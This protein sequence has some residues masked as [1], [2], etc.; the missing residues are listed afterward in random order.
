MINEILFLILPKIA[1]LTELEIMSELLFFD[2]PLSWS[3]G[4]IEDKEG[5]RGG[6]CLS[7]QEKHYIAHVRKNA[8]GSWAEPHLLL[9]HLNGTARLA[10][11]YTTK[12]Q[13]A[14]WGKAAGLAH[15]AGKGRLV[16][17]NYLRLKSGFFD[18]EAHLEGKPGKMPHAV[19]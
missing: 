13:S 8:D 16:W 11:I 15:D 7:D 4:R 3:S 9:E 5:N 6:K 1:F 14:K 18:E 2:H 17:Q 10:E 19:Q 12:F